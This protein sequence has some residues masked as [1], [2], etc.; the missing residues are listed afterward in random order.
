MRWTFGY[1][2]SSASWCSV[3]DA[4]LNAAFETAWRRRILGV[5]AGSTLDCAAMS[6]PEGFTRR[7]CA[8]LLAD[9]SGYSALVGKDDAR[10][11]QDV[12]RLQEIVC[13]IVADAR[14]HAEPRAGDSIL[15]T[16]DSVVAAVDAG[17]AI[18][19]RVGS[20][21]FTGT[22]LQVR[23][24]IH[25]GDVL[26]R[27]GASF[28][29]AVGDAI[30]IA[31]RLEALARPGTICVS[32]GVYRHVRHKLDETFVD[33]GRQQLKH[34]SDPI[35]AYLI[36]PRELASAY[37]LPWRRRRATW[38]VSAALAVLLAV[39][40]PFLPRLFH[41]TATTPD[42]QSGRTPSGVHTA[43]SATVAADATAELVTLGVMG[44]KSLGEA[45]HDDWRREALRDGLNTQLSRLSRVKVYSKEFID[46]LI[47][48]KGLTEIEAATQLGIRKML[49][50]SFAARKGTLQIEIH[51]VDVETGVLQASYTT[52]GAEESFLD[53]QNQ[54]ALDVVSRLDLPVSDAEKQ[55]LLAQQ[56]AD[57]KAWR[58][59]LEAEGEVA[60]PTPTKVPPESRSQSG[61]FWS[62]IGSL[63][64][65]ALADSGVPSEEAIRAFFDRYQ[66][67]M[68]GREVQGLAELYTEFPPELQA[69]QQRYF[70][71]V[72]DL[73][74]AI[75]DLDIAVIGDE[76]VVSYTRT[77]DFTD[78][79]TGRPMRV[80]VRVTKILRQ[81]DGTWRLTAQESH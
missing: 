72:R 61:G 78:V 47:S 26:L 43:A 32:D 18:L 40:A 45:G 23:I 9:V 27:N 21:S 12:S 70:D 7:I 48:R 16:F 53:L 34:I 77:D 49:S 62:V 13:R 29:E 41:P 5:P 25:L 44:F 75:D 68:E 60:I 46:F 59:F 67:A 74:V 24:G 54:L 28:N 42:A 56:T 51:V 2:D 38:G 31:A 39:A 19:R 66:R 79:G 81:A 63:G 37:R 1:R 30:N 76:A 6:A 3:A 52:S 57:V 20:E 36:V 15:A 11:A 8:V 14:G 17:L 10:A 50:G 55:V 73:R 71:N 65:P 4:D 35:H 22:P 64:S 58:R 80:A 69:A 33:L